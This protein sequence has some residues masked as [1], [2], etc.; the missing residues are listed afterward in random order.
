MC[1]F[2]CSQRYFPVLYLWLVLLC[3]GD[4]ERNTGPLGCVLVCV[5]GRRLLVGAL[6]ARRAEVKGTLAAA[7]SRV[8]GNTNSWR[9]AEFASVECAKELMDGGESLRTT[10]SVSLARQ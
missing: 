4:V 9:K 10:K 6:L 3:A 1:E 2:L 8:E 5:V 7:V